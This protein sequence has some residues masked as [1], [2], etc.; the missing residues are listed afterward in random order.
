[1]KRY[2]QRRG[3]G[4]G[5]QAMVE[6]LVG[7]VAVISLLAGLLQIVTLTR[8]HLDAMVAARA[9]AGGFAILDQ[10]LL[11]DPD[12]IRD[13]DAG[14]DARRHTRDDDPDLSVRVGEFKGTIVNRAGRNPNVAPR[15]WELIESLPDPR[16]GQ[17]R[18]S[19]DPDTL[20]GLVKG[21]GGGRVALTNA[22][23]HLLY[24]AE[25]I[26][27]DADVWLTR[28]GGVYR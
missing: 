1:M 7:L 23:R 14:P 19:D 18:D 11:F 22:V 6:F 20:F 28:T 17:M 24:R 26:D 13:W 3:A 25:Y 16:L 12:Y 15:D 4:S 9:E 21:H 5:G 8:T 10:N 27:V 2:R